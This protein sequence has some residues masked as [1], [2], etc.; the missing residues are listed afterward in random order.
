MRLPKKPLG[1]FNTLLLILYVCFF[2]IDVF[3]KEITF[4]PWWFFLVLIALQ[5]VQ[6]YF[7]YRGILEVWVAHFN[8]ATLMGMLQLALVLK[9]DYFHAVVYWA[10][11]VPILVSTTLDGRHSLV[12][13][14]LTV[15]F[16]LFN[17]LHAYV[18]F[19]SYTLEIFPMR[20]MITGLIYVFLT[21]FVAVLYKQMRDR[22]SKILDVKNKRL[23][24]QRM[25]LEALN[26][27]LTLQHDQL[28]TA[29]KQLLQSEK[30]ASLGVLSAGIGHE[31]NNP[32]H[33]IKSG[34][35]GLARE[36]DKDVEDV[37]KE[38]L[39]YMKVIQEGVSRANKIVKSLSH[40]SRQT[41]TMDESC[42]IH[43]ILENCLSILHNKLK[44]R[45]EVFTDYSATTHVVVGNEG[46]LHQAFLNV[47]TNAEQ[48]MDERGKLTVS[49]KSSGSDIRVSIS[50]TGSGIKE[51]DLDKIHDPFFTTKEPGLGTGLGLAITHK[52]LEEHGVRVEVQSE[53][54]V[55][56]EF[57]L[58][59]PI[60]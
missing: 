15:L 53:E 55:G 46:K 3:I 17:G 38:T 5:L 42:D 2:T 29:Q 7:L 36:L 11:V 48:S 23:A 26:K 31:I 8:L 56:T 40:F 49:T 13:Y 33:F 47:L 6:M 59:F 37:R 16:V 24:A 43:G 20:F 22:Q 10:A 21:I 57:V 60:K 27:E 35:D 51:A 39:P 50:D 4:M 28:L 58:I 12:W 30:M 41:V 19:G 52:I 18:Q 14:V 34:V 45:V 32:L 44:F 54:N 25:R 9:P 1:K